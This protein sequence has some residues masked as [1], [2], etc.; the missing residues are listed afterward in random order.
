MSAVNYQRDGSMALNNQGGAPKYFPN[1]FNGPVECPAVKSPRYYVS[2]EVDRHYQPV[3]ADDYVQPGIFWR[4]V[5]QPDEKTRLVRNIAGD[6]KNASTFI[7]ERAV[8]NFAN[9]DRELGTR[10]IDELR[11][12]GASINACGKSAHL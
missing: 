9:V 7:I 12:S 10:L 1:S 5:L 11:K 4:R 3:T 8:E 6:L 2:G